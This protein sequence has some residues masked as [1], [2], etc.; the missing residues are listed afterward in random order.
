MSDPTELRRLAE[1]APL[2]E[3]QERIEVPL[4]ALRALLAERDALR[5]AAMDALS[6][7]VAAV[8]LLEGGGK[9]AAPSDKMFR[10]MLVDYNNSITRARQALAKEAP[11]ALK[12]A[13][14]G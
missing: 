7:L 1:A 9:K 5:G 6:S 10:Q 4:P 3:L 8:S 14:N 2:G 13:G 11:D 12:D